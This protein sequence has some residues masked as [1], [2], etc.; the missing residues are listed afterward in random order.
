MGCSESAQFQHI[1][2][3]YKNLNESSVSVMVLPF[4]QKFID[5]AQR[6]YW[7][8]K[9]AAA[10][11]T[12]SARETEL[13]DSYFF[14]ILSEN[15]YVK[16]IHPENSLNLKEIK[17]IHQIEKTEREQK[18]DLY[19]PDKSSSE[20]IGMLSN[21]TLVISDLYFI[22]DYAESASYLGR[23]TQ[24][25][26]ALKGGMEYLLWDNKKNKISCYGRLE[27]SV[28]LMESP[29]KETYLSIFDIFAS[30][31]IKHSPFAAKKIY[32]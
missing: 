32:Y 30:A 12:L 7:M 17:F 2:S 9:K 6:E 4:I 23:G 15:T 1:E 20:K 16:I 26:Y 19:L 24:E 27:Q 5:P 22:K 21:F 10:K 8:E 28:R 29:T 25:S 14:Q 18:I 31:I 13:F 3:E 11:K